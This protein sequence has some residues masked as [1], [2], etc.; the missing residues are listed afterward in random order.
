MGRPKNENSCINYKCKQCGKIF[1]Y[2][3]SHK[4]VFCSNKC[5]GE[6]IIGKRNPAWKNGTYRDK[7]GYITVYYLNHPFPRKKGD[8]NIYEHRLVME[9]YLRKTQPNHPALIEID[10]VKYLR[11]EW[12]VH[13][14]GI[15]YLVGSFE[16]RGDNRIKN[17]KLFPNE[18]EHHKIHYP[19]GKKFSK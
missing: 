17:L 5:Q 15:K 6:F 10:G 2:W 12:I 7:R 1:E 18:S 14:K 16:N 8:N 4:R 13:H 19:K 3:K 11:P 9:Q